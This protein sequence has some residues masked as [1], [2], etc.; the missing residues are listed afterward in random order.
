VVAVATAP[1]AVVP[2]PPAPA[3]E[4]RDDVPTAPRSEGVQIEPTITVE[5]CMAVIGALIDWEKGMGG[6]DAPIWREAEKLIG[7]QDPRK[8]KRGEPEE[9]H[10]IGAW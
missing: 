10:V 7:A 8:N 9:K 5:R 3:P 2:L 1:A 4:I 6:W